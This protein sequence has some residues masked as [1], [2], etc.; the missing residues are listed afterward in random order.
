MA[1]IRTIK[2]DFF[3]HFGLYTAE[4]E[5]GLPLRVSFAGLL[6]ACDREGRFRWKPEALKLD[7]LPYDVID[8]SRV[9]D[10]LLTRGFIVRYTAANEL[11]GWVPTFLKH[12]VI[13]NRERESDLPNPEDPTI[14]TRAPRDSDACPTPPLTCTRGNGIGNGN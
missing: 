8:F 10:A 6:T 13:N 2:P 12:Q 4:I 11:Y 9:L 5:T 1:R 7:C 14:S 3:R